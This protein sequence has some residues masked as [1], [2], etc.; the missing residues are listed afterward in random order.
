LSVEVRAV[1]RNQRFENNQRIRWGITLRLEGSVIGAC[2]FHGWA[3]NHF[4]IE[5]G[6]ELTPE[7]WQQGSRESWV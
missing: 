6:Y 1:E 3:K 5:T 7:Y 2:G 4:K